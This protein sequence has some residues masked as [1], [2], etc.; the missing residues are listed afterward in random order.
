MV[1]GPENK[2]REA[3]HNFKT[4]ETRQYKVVSAAFNDYLKILKIILMISM[5]SIY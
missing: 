2:C 5:Y 3:I 4:S 1:V